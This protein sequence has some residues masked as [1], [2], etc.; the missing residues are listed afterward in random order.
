MR[1]KIILTAYYREDIFD[2]IKNNPI[3][4][5]KRLSPFTSDFLIKMLHKDPKERLG[6]N[7]ICEI[8]D[9]PFFEEI[10]WLKLERRQIKPSYVPKLRK[11]DDIKYIDENWLEEGIESSPDIK[12][13]SQ[14]EKEKLHVNNF[15]F[16]GDGFIDLS[17]CDSD[18]EESY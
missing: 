16:H 11:K 18:N 5:S 3:K 15:S 1:I 14:E 8:M 9:H 10:D 12:M 4:I 13:L 7:G 6:T 2:C 17:K